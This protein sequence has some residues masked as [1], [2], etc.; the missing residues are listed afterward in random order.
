MNNHSCL[1]GIRGLAGE[2]PNVL[3]QHA[4]AIA[5]VHTVFGASFAHLYCRRPDASSLIGR[6]VA[7]DLRC[8]AAFAPGEPR[9]RNVSLIART[10]SVSSACLTSMRSLS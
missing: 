8:Q 7:R 5:A 1:A 10:R 4:A 6:S 2:R 9:A 3:V